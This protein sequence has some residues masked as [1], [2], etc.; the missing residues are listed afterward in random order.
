MGKLEVGRQSSGAGGK[1]D[2]DIGLDLI[3]EDGVVGLGVSDG[4]DGS[5]G[6]D[7]MMAAEAPEA[8]GEMALMDKS[9]AAVATGS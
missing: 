6:R 2:I 3:K 7:G 9:A 5:Q 1:M 4:V 8:S